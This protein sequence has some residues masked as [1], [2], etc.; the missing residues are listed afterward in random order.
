M[1]RHT[2]LSAL[3]RCHPTLTSS[4]NGCAP[5]SFSPNASVGIASSQ[6]LSH[7]LPRPF[8][9]QLHL[10]PTRRSSS[11]PQPKPEPESQP[12]SQ[13]ESDSQP[14][15][16]P[17]TQLKAHISSDDLNPPST[18]RPPPLVLPTKTR[19]TSTFKHLYSTGKAFLTFYKTGLRQIWT[20]TQL[21]RSL[22]APPSCPEEPRSLTLLRLRNTHDLRRLPLFAVLL[23]ICG[24]FTPLVVLI[25]PQIVPFTCRIPRQVRKL[26]VAAE[27]RRAA[28]RREGRWRRESG[29]GTVAGRGEAAPLV[30]TVEM[31]IVARVLGLVGQGWDR[32]GWVPAALAQGRVGR[33]R[34]FVVR[35]DGM[36][37]RRE[38]GVGRLEDDEVELAC[39]D[40]GINTVDRDVGELRSVLETWLELTGGVGEE[41][42]IRRMEWLVLHGEE[43]WPE[44]WPP[45]S[46]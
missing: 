19:T 1:T 30:E 15:P 33:W 45:K 43:E 23:L 9:R 44:S 10:S 22:P 14:E 35:D 26:R 39:V 18:T 46:V 32:I 40:R 11:A 7:A 29:L 2:S 3:R 41:E 37:R 28:A 38:D 21:V 42:V 31:P 6:L 13:P 25:L 16:S 12:E 24:E 17:I 4:L 34:E 36:L 20:N 5:L 8:S 27:E